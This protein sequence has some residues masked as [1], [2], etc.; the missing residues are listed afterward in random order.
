MV[1]E[2]SVFSEVTIVNEGGSRI[3]APRMRNVS[4][5][6]VYT[7]KLGCM[8]TCILVMKFFLSTVF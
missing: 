1:L 5:L 3:P 7:V 2:T 8:S 4:G 6:L